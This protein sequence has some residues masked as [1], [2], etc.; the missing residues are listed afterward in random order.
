MNLSYLQSGL[1]KERKLKTLIGLTIFSIAGIF[2]SAHAVVYCT[3]PGVPAGCVVRPL[4]TP[5]LGPPGVGVGAPGAG[6]VDPGINQPGAAGNVGVRR[7]GMGVGTPGAGVVDPG[8]NQPG[9]VGNVG[10]PA[11]LGGPVNRP[12]LR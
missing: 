2:Q 4:V 11:N 6:V 9:A 12:G 3:G 1:I 5:G 8:I 7:P 10:G